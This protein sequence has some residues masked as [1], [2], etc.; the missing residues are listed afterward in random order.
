MDLEKL[1]AIQLR[2]VST[3]QSSYLIGMQRLLCCLYVYFNLDHQGIK[4]VIPKQKTM[5]TVTPTGRYP[6]NCL[7]EKIPDGQDPKWT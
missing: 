2:K 7:N 1:G 6:D 4:S 3:K 5:K